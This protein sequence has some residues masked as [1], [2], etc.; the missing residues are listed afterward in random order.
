MKDRTFVILFLL[1]VV[2]GAIL[3]YQVKQDKDALTDYSRLKKGAVIED[4][5]LIDSREVVIGSNDFDPG[6]IYAIFVF[7]K[8]CPSCEPNLFFWEKLL[9]RYRDTFIPLG[10]MFTGIDR[11]DFLIEMTANGGTSFNL[12]CPVN[13][14]RFREILKIRFKM[15]SKTVLLK[16]GRVLFYRTGPIGADEYTIIRKIIKGEIK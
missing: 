5:Y 16:G 8:A 15:V 3:L 7:S 13:E 9:K 11:I 2:A 12:F 1:L 4:F 14:E 10:V 6:K